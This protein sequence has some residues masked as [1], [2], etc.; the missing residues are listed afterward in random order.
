MLSPC[1]DIVCLS[2]IVLEETSFSEIKVGP[3]VTKKEWIE[4]TPPRDV[5]VPCPVKKFSTTPISKAKRR[6]ND[7]SDSEQEEEAKPKSTAVPTKKVPKVSGGKTDNSNSQFKK[8]GSKLQVKK[9][10]TKLITKDATTDS[11]CEFVIESAPKIKRKSQLN[12]PKS[13][14][15]V[16]HKAE[17]TPEQ[18][19]PVGEDASTAASESKS[20]TPGKENKRQSVEN[21]KTNQK[22]SSSSPN[23][24]SE[25]VSGHADLP[26]FKKKLSFDKNKLSS[27]LMK[28]KTSST[29]LSSKNGANSEKLLGRNDRAGSFDSLSSANTDSTCLDLIPPETPRPLDFELESSSKAERKKQKKEKSEYW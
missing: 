4:P 25:L 28:L 19:S 14:E 10:T 27:A 2:I 21:A 8:E 6:I 29:D 7:S 22:R 17:I 26:P 24:T 12:T 15:S 20:M 5:E 3:K 11:D 23:P 9:E 13:V 18:T 1:C 16:D